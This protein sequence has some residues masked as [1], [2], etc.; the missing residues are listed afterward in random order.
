MLGDLF[1]LA[2]AL[3][4]TNVS[5]QTL[6]YTSAP[7]TWAPRTGLDMPKDVRARLYQMHGEGQ[8]SE[9]AFQALL[10]LAEQGQLR[11]ADLA[12]H[13]VRARRGGAQKGDA[14]IGN[15]LRGI[16]SRLGQLH[17]ART[18]SEKALAGLETSLR[19]LDE[20]IAAKEQAARQVVAQDE[21]TARR[22][23]ADKAELSISRARVADQAQASRADL[24]RLDDL[25]VQL[26]GKMIELESVQARSVTAQIFR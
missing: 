9:E 19:E 7:I 14:A 5:G 2:D 25:S 22:Y 16:R 8:I 20:R 24:A 18:D 13:Q 26:K 17:R 1:Y 6:L 11:P 4:A 3:I 21:E 15:A 23:L 12:V 10:V